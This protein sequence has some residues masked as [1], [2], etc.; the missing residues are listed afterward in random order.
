MFAAGSG[1]SAE[2]VVPLVIGLVGPSTVIDVGC[3]TGLWLREFKRRGVRDVLGIDFCQ[4]PD[5]EI[6]LE[7]EEFVRRDLALTLCLDR[8]FDLA[9]CLEVAEH[10][11]EPVADRFVADLT[12]LAPVI[13]FSAAVPHQG[14]V[15]HVNEQWPEYWAEKFL[16]RSYVAADAIRSRIW[17]HPAVDFWYAQNLLLFVAA[18]ELERNEI[19]R[20]AAESTD[21][22]ALARVHPSLYLASVEAARH[23]WKTLTS[24]TSTAIRRTW[25]RATAGSSPFRNTLAPDSRWNSRD[26]P[27]QSNANRFAPPP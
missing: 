21:P 23:P 27:P 7:P 5:E 6:V 3:G 4:I 15:G 1:A 18:D 9:L 13:V 26:K 17:T 2:V 16:A 20:A 11:P 10:L 8:H 24:R 19:V 12:R 25:G 14:G 22:L